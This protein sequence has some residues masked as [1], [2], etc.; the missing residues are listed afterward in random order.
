M[1]LEF[2]SNIFESEFYVFKILF[3]VRRFRIFFELMLYLLHVWFKFFSDEWE[4]DE[5]G[6]WPTNNGNHDRGTDNRPESTYDSC[7][8]IRHKHLPRRS[9]ILHKFIE[10]CWLY[11]I[12]ES[13][14]LFDFMFIEFFDC[15]FSRCWQ[16]FN[17][18]FFC[19]VFFHMYLFY[20]KFSNL[21][22]LEFAKPLIL[23]IVFLINENRIQIPKCLDLSNL[24]IISF[25][26][27]PVAH[28]E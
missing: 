26:L 12:N 19:E 9:N 14:N 24:L 3:I 21:Q 28:V 7:D 18:L 6:K 5:Q 17:L 8:K 13:L 23:Y 22:K 11:G 16:F 20:H 4:I 10:T 27:V 25:V 2:F 15:F 1:F